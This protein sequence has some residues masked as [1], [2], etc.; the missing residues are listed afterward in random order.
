ML[1]RCC[2]LC[3]CSVLLGDRYVKA[4]TTSRLEKARALTVARCVGG[5][6]GC[7]SPYGKSLSAQLQETLPF[8]KSL[9]RP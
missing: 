3:A 9:A 5:C 1:P 2:V 4:V 6:S 8:P 7:S